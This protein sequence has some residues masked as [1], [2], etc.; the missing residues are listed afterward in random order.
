MVRKIVRDS[1]KTIA[2]GIT[3]GAGLF[4]ILWLT[5]T[6][7]AG[8]DMASGLE[9]ARA[10][11]FIGGA[12]GL[13]VL[14]GSNLFFRQKQ[15]W[16]HKDAWKKIYSVFSYKVVLGIASLVVLIMASALDYVLYY[17]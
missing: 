12:L 17:R 1:V 7:A 15:E 16:K 10:G 5:G 13:F 4:V 6:L 2:L 14:A 3:A 9:T 8:W 11:M